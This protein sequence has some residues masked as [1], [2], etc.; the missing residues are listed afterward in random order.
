MIPRLVHVVWI[1]GT[2]NPHQDWLESWTRLNPGWELRHWT[3]NN[4]PQTRHQAIIDQIP[5]NSGKVNLI[6]LE[7][8]H[9]F[10]GLYSDADSECLKPLDPLV[11]GIRSLGMT[12][13]KGNVQNATLACEPGDPTY[14]RM[15]DDVPA[16]WRRLKSSR[17]NA[18]P[19]VN[20]RAVFGAKYI[21]RYLQ[22]D[23]RFVQID[24]GK[25]NGSRRLICEQ[26]ERCDDTVIVHYM[27]QSWKAQL[28][29]RRVRL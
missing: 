26:H 21:T 5:H 22:A 28:G 19:G 12:G 8:L 13:R 3:D 6:R 17:R 25:R 23:P 9:W 7:L 27:D 18:G 11:D 24:A 10:G 15:L 4:L 1:G 16:W 29:G 2:P 20:F 14:K